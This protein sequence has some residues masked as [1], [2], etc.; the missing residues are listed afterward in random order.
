MSTTPA[1]VHTSAQAT[2]ATSAA[3]LEYT[4]TLI[5]PAEARNRAAD[6]EGHM[7]PVIR[8]ELEL[9]NPQRTRLVAEQR[10]PVGHHAQAAAA[11][12]RLK[13]GTQITIAAPLSDIRLFAGNTA[14][15]HV[16][17]TD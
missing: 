8:C 7:V 5:K 16:I 2:P 14:H 4:G 17:T 15:I 9:N 1:A 3:L 6:L 11:A 10:F 12:K 13:K